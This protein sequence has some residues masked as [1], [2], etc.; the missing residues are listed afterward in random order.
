[1][2]VHHPP[3]LIDNHSDTVDTTPDD[4][5]PTGAVP[6]TTQDLRDEGVEVR[7]NK[8]TSRT[9]HTRLS[10]YSVPHK[11]TNHQH[12]RRDEDPEPPTGKGS[13][14]KGDDREPQIGAETDASVS[15]D[16]DI[17]VGLEPATK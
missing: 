17:E 6:E 3:D 9:R 4:E 12:R 16:R 13:G 10:S 7:V 8:F 2:P 14:D 5:V 1:M 11:D 15:S